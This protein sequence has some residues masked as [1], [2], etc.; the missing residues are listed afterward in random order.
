MQLND[1][2]WRFFGVVGIIT[3]GGIVILFAYCAYDALRDV[4][5][6]WRWERKYKHRFDK[7]PTAACYCK[8]CHYHSKSNKCDNVTWA[9]RY[10]PSNGFC[11]DAIPMTAEEAKKREQ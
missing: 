2:F 9:D 1:G 5:R 10:T 7:P 11:Y 3:A 6:Q 4:I 8:D